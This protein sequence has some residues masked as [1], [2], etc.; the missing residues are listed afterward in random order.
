VATDPKDS[1]ALSN[2][3]IAHYW[4][5]EN[6]L[7]RADF[8]AAAKL[9][10]RDVVALHGQG[11]LALRESRL[12]DAI[13]AFTRAADLLENNAFALSN[14]ASAYQQLGQYDNALADLDE[15]QRLNPQMS[16]LVVTR[17]DLL[18][19]QFWRPG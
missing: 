5:G 16:Q 15:L 2:R 1:L 10:G 11:L 19:S 4:K 9:N 17:A 13:A 3:G 14:R 6:E 7:A 8:A 18:R 12:P